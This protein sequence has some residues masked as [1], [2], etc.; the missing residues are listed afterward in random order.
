MME[1][2][3]VVGKSAQK[4]R[5]VDDAGDIIISTDVR[6]VVQLTGDVARATRVPRAVGIAKKSRHGAP[7]GGET[8]RQRWHSLLKTNNN[9]GETV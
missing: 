9:N 1:L 7:N 2:R 5:C 4:E 8:L 6:R 3:G